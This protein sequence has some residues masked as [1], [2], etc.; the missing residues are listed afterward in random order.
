MPDNKWEKFET[1]LVKDFWSESEACHIFAGLIRVVRRGS[2]KPSLQIVEEKQTIRAK[3]REQDRI[4]EVWDGTDHKPKG[5]EIRSNGF[6]EEYSVAYCIRWAQKKR[7]G[8]PWLDWAIKEGYIKAE[9]LEPENNNA[10]ADRVPGSD[11]AVT[12]EESENTVKNRLRLIGLM[13]SMMQNKDKVGVMP[14][15]NQDHL[16][17]VIAK[18]YSDKYPNRGLAVGTVSKLLAKANNVLSEDKV[19]KD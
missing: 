10:D 5:R 2:I 6:T 11:A 3:E 19:D 17:K 13:A 15:D 12:E 14:F 4:K 16:A 8:I 9:D 18:T 1:A 7:I